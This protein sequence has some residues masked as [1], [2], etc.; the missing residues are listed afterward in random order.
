M[1]A[2][3]SAPVSLLPAD[4][5][6]GGLAFPFPDAPRPGVAVTVADGLWWLR[7]PLP[8]ALDHIN[9]WLL[10]DGEGVTVVDTGFNAQATRDAWDEVFRQHPPAVRMIATHYHP[11][12]LGLA[13]WLAQRFGIDLWT[14]QAEFLT[15]HAVWEASAGYEPGSLTALFRAHG[16]AG[17]RLEAVDDRGNHYR[18]AVWPLPRTYRRLSDGE[19]FTVDGRAWRVIVGTGHAPEHAA[20]HC[21]S[22]GVLISG[23]M[24]L[25]RISTNTS[26]WPPEPDGDPVGQFLV[27]I[28]RFTEL[29]EDTLV[30]PAHGLP[31]R[32]IAARVAALEAHHAER[33]GEL[34]E[35]SRAAPVTAADA[36]PVLFRR[37][38]DNHQLF[39]AMGEAIAHLNHLLRRGALTR[40]RDAGGVYRFRAA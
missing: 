3:S 15:A 27:S 1:P 28:R 29:P 21:P 37:P 6:R 35:A 23:D 18:R 13:G 26:V 20:L 30:L 19:T 34:L 12:H 38:L 9:L 11:D 10:R 2:P 4:P 16:L 8:F 33:L 7:M 36:L 39:F 22:L 24:L 40:S 17:E 31:F 5:A 14:T 32:G 25:P